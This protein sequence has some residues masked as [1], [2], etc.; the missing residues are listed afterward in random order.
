MHLQLTLIEG[1][2]PMV[3]GTGDTLHSP[4]QGRMRPVQGILHGLYVFR[5][6]QDFH[7][8]LLE[9]GRL[10]EAEGACLGRHIVGIKEEATS[11]RGL[12][13]SR[14]LTP[15]ERQFAALRLAG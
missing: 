9:D 1:A 11:V 6:I 4:W 5:V 2:V 13:G 10:M 3:A 7:R 12:T 15:E 14:D 8:A